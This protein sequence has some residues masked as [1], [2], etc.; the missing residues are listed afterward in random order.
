MT[1][2]L[3]KVF[4]ASLLALVMLIGAWVVADIVTDA[5]LKATLASLK[6][7]GYATTLADAAPAAPPADKNAAPLYRKAFEELT[8]TPDHGVA[9]PSVDKGGF[10]ALSKPD[11]A[12][13]RDW[14]AAN[15]E[16]LGQFAAARAY[17]TCV[18]DRDWSKGFA[19]LLPEIASV[20][21]AGRT[22]SYRAQAFVEDGKP[23][24]ARAAVRDGFALADSIEKDPFLVS[25]LVRV[26]VI[27]IHLKVVDFGVRADATEAELREWLK[28]VP[29]YDHFNGMM[30]TAMRG[31]LAT[32]AGMAADPEGLMAGIG[33]AAP[34]AGVLRPVFANDLRHH[35]SNMRRATE[36]CRLPPWEASVAIEKLQKEA[37]S[38]VNWLHPVTA[39][40][41]PAF[42]KTVENQKRVMAYLAVVRSGLECELA[43]A[44]TKAYPATLDVIDPFT[45]KPLVYKPDKG[46][47]YSF[48]PDGD[49]DGGEPANTDPGGEQAGDI[50]WKLR[51]HH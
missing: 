31:E 15:A 48:G 13:L 25:Q 41:M 46:L 50:V 51:K 11:Q 14:L 38:V 17:G 29:A 44:T 18:F 49:D 37:V 9:V 3:H 6:K 2:D 1:V 27:S 26:V 10:R 12:K 47:L 5:R 4:V 42:A 35:L 23:E 45:G 21:K 30:E 34:Y 7:D 24:A 20:V 22:L 36:A 43:H 40:L 28:L 16:T 39:I 32:A 19:V 33:A 8:A